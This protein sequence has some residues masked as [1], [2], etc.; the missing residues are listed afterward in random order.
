M[1]E[2]ESLSHSKWECKVSATLSRS[3][4]PLREVQSCS[5]RQH[6]SE[7]WTTRKATRSSFGPS[8][9]GSSTMRPYALKLSRPTCSSMLP[10]S[11]S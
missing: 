1:D 6:R 9:I 11:V 4:S 2:Y 10:E 5:M 7:L 3:F 8:S